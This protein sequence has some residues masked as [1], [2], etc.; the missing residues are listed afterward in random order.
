MSEQRAHPRYAIELDADLEFGD[1][2]AS[3]KGRTHDI[4]RGGFSMLA[5]ADTRSVDSGTQCTVRVA[6]VFSETEFSEQIALQ[7]TVMW[8]TRLRGGVQIGI[9]F[10]ALDAQAREYLDLF[11]HFLES[12][13]EDDG[14][15]A[16]DDANSDD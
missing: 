12:G 11:M 4:S 9:K 7:G 15:G 1:G 2:N 6:L 8:C 14:D 3:I 13:E 5:K 16:D 10:A